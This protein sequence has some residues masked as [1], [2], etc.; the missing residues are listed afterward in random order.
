VAV[1][2]FKENRQAINFIIQSVDLLMPDLLNLISLWGHTLLLIFKI[3]CNY[4]TAYG[5]D[6]FENSCISNGDSTYIHVFG[7]IPSSSAKS[8]HLTPSAVSR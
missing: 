7:R 6:T 4:S 3:P 5:S 1:V 8:L 2:Y